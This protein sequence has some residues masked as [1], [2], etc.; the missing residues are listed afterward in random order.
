[1]ERIY[2]NIQF[3]LTN[4]FAIINHSNIDFDCGFA[5]YRFSGLSK[6]D[7]FCVYG[8]IVCFCTLQQQQHK[9]HILDGREAV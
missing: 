5:L 1:M 4:L 9:T 8:I 6:H 2:L 3:Y 7:T